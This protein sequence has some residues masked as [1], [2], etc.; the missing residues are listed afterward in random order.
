MSLN[1]R[2]IVK[3]LLAK[4][5]LDS[6]S[7]LTSENARYLIQ[8]LAPAILALVREQVAE[9]RRRLSGALRQE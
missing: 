4:S 7:P 6:R 3:L 9:E 8:M 2:Q 5:D 1:E